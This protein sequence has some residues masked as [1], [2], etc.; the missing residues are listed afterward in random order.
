MQTMKGEIVTIIQFVYI[1]RWKTVLPTEKLL[2]LIK[3]QK[4]GKATCPSYLHTYCSLVCL[5]AMCIYPGL[6]SSLTH[7][8]LS[9]CFFCPSLFILWRHTMFIYITRSKPIWT[10]APYVALKAWL[11]ASQSSI[12]Y[13]RYQ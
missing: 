4:E 2:L 11:L 9:S 13:F 10:L 6:C 7:C 1:I 5:H 12:L 8:Q 3:G